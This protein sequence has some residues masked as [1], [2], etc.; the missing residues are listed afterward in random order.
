MFLLVS[1]NPY[2]EYDQY[3]VIKAQIEYV[4]HLTLRVYII[5]SA[6]TALVCHVGVYVQLL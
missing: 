5:E 6:S 1:I 2:G 3:E 4:W